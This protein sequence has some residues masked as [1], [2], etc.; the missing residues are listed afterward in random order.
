MPNAPVDIAAAHALWDHYR[1]AHPDRATDTELPSVEQ[2]GD[3]PALTDELLGL[4]L[5]GAKRATASLVA[6]FAAESQALPRIGSHWIA[7]DSTGRPRA[8]L[9]S[10]ELRIGTFADADEEFAHDEGEDD[11]TLASW[12]E[13]H[14]RYWQRVAPRSASSGPKRTRS[15]SS[16]S[17]SPGATTATAGAPNP[18]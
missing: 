4:V 10:T 15:S 11:R 5:D 2:F 12:R 1:A 3:H 14:R 6:E 13:N 7:C 18:G 17:R 16:D 8:I 9:R